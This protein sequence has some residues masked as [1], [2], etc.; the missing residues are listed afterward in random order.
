LYGSRNKQQVLPYT[1]LKTGFYNRGGVFTAR[2]A[3][4]PHMTR[5]RLV[6]KRLSATN[7]S[8]LVTVSLRTLAGTFR[9]TDTLPSDGKTR[10]TAR[11]LRSTYGVAQDPNLLEFYAVQIGNIAVIFRVEKT[12]ED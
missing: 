2:Y 5:I 1:S 12:Q 3:L 9:S 4:I 7:R 11:N 10:N 6:F 8:K